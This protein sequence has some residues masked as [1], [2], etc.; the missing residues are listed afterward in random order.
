M[1]FFNGHFSLKKLNLEHLP[2]LF[3]I[4][5]TKSISRAS[6]FQE[7]LHELTE[8]ANTYLVNTTTTRSQTSL[9]PFGNTFRFISQNSKSFVSWNR[10]KITMFAKVHWW[11]CSSILDSHHFFKNKYKHFLVPR[12]NLIVQFWQRYN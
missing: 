12:S 8:S 1:S 6:R 5:T 2:K 4:S 3:F 10:N 11:T 9:W 7:S